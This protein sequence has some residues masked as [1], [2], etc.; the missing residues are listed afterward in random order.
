MDYNKSGKVDCEEMTAVLLSSGIFRGRKDVS[1]IFSEYDMDKSGDIT[2]EEFLCL[3]RNYSK[4]LDLDR[5]DDLVDE[6]CT[7]SSETLLSQQRR[8]MLMQYVVNESVMRDR[9]VEWCTNGLLSAK[10]KRGTVRRL[11]TMGAVEKAQS[12][13]RLISKVAID[14]IET[15]LLSDIT[16]RPILDLCEED[17]IRI[18]ARMG[19]MPPIESVVSPEILPLINQTEWKHH[20]NAAAKIFIPPVD[21]PMVQ[22]RDRKRYTPQGEL[23]DKK[24]SPQ[25]YFRSIR[26]KLA[27]ILHHA[28]PHSPSTK[29]QIDT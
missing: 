2:F 11:Q 18:E 5:L 26:P 10:T 1:G 12:K 13:L 23:A 15:L 7:L 4:H 8:G 27:L 9:E 16:A 25:S 14:E 17:K 19:A 28:P 22:K 6:T 20:T 3:I 29:Y 24:K 21:C